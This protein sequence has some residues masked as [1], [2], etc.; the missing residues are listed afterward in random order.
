MAFIYAET[1]LVINLLGLAATYTEFHFRLIE[2]ALVRQQ[3]TQVP[4][5]H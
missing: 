1:L 5:S 4:M 3:L 2:S